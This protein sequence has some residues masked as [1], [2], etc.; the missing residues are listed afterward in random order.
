MGLHEVSAV[1]AQYFSSSCLLWP[2]EMAGRRFPKIVYLSDQIYCSLN[3]ALYGSFEQYV[4]SYNI[5]DTA[6][7]VGNLMLVHAGKLTVGE[8]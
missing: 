2:V 8:H 1:R 4:H 7:L 5:C 6:V 3:I